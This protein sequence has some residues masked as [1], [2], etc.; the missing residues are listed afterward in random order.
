LL[1]A[2]D[3]ASATATGLTDVGFVAVQ[4]RTFR[5]PR[6]QFFIPE[7]GHY[8]GTGDGTTFAL[9]N[10]SN[11]RGGSR[12]QYVPATV[13]AA[14]DAAAS[15]LSPPTNF[16]LESGTAELLIQQDGTV[17][18]RVKATWTASVDERVLAYEIQFKRATDV[19][20]ST[21]PTVF[22]LGNTTQWI[23]GVAD[24]MLFDFRIRSAGAVRQVSD[25][26]TIEDYFVIG[27]SEKPSNVGTISF[28]DP[29]LSWPAVT[30]NDLDGYIVRYHP[31]V[32]T[33]WASATPAHVAGFITENRFDTGD[34]VGGVTTM[35][36]KS[37]DT[38]ANESTSVSSLQVDLRPKTPTSFSISRQPDGTREFTW[39]TTTPP[40][41][42]DGLRI[43][44]FLGTT[45]DW[46][47]MTPLHT[48][49][50]KASPFE[51][52]QL[53]AGIY[54]FA[55][56]NVDRAGNESA[57]AI[58]ITTVTIG[59]PR[60]QGVIED[61]KEEP[62]WTETK[63]DCHVDVVT[64]WLVADGLA[65]WADLPATWSGWTQ[66]NYNPKSPIIYEREI[67]IGIKI[68]F[69]PLITVESDGAQVIE[70]QHSDDGI[71]WSAWATT[72]ALIDAQYIRIRVTLTGS[73]PIFK[74]MR[75]ILSTSTISEIVEDQDSASLLG[76]Y[77]IGAGD[78]RVP[79]TQVYNLIK[80]VD[81]TLQ[82]VGAGWTWELIDKDMTVG[83]RIKI[84]NASNA[85]ADAVF[86]ATVT[87]V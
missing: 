38:S 18:T 48:G 39:T 15:T 34:I 84:Y 54:T 58:F 86:D 20:W 69:I 28:T 9:P 50:L 13:A 57:N 4:G 17:V 51:T 36:V 76:A 30:D 25:W 66:W 60:I 41:D 45:A 8:D 12:V 53:A 59:D 14:P 22:G 49:V 40:A 70:E 87:G 46:S 63:T 79:I 24:G 44:Y 21:A 2:L 10:L 73:Y 19:N 71:A 77:R 32:N 23:V 83:P 55:G 67:D 78:I 33:D 52:N 82:S 62:F 37:V 6:D 68:K 42:L 5:L 74:T 31:G 81:I 35:L 26:L 29:H 43:R 72:G 75:V 65:T 56:K 16:G 3:G 64:G 1:I 80:K 11:A 27:K 47:V 7:G 85:L 61:Y